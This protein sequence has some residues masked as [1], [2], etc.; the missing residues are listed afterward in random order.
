M[1]ERTVVKQVANAVL[2]SDGT[3]RLDNVRASHPHVFVA[4]EG[5]DDKGNPTPAKFS[6]QV[7]MPKGSHKAAK[8]LLVE[9]I[10]DMLREHKTKA[11]PP[12]RKFIRDGDVSG[13]DEQEG[14]WVISASEKNRPQLRNRDP[15]IP[16]TEKHSD[17]IYGG[18]YVNV[19]IRPWW[20]DNQYGK[21]VNAG[22]SA[23][24]F[25][26]DGEP[27]GTGRITADDVDATFESHDDGMGDAGLDDDDDHGL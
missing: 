20:Q 25:L 21:R 12:E 13:K 7:F 9:V 19:L 22:L 3:I 23:V 2:Y 26:R 1:A 17:I 4:K 5:K 24:Q 6:I 16:L 18:C 8:D 27:F 15:R 14:N 11:L 10:N